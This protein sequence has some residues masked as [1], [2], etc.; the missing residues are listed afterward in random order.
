MTAVTMGL[1]LGTPAGLERLAPVGAVALFLLLIWDL[2]LVVPILLVS[3][4]FGPKFAFEFGNL[5]LSTGILLIAYLAWALRIPVREGGLSFKSGPILVALLAMMVAFV[6]SSL[7]SYDR[8]LSEIP[9]FMRFFQFLLYTGIF[10][11]VRQMEFSRAQIR[12]LII[13]MLMVGLAQGAYGAYQ[14]WSRP[15]YFV[16]GTF[17]EQHNLFASYV[18]FIAVIMVG[19][20]MEAR[21]LPVAIGFLAAA[22][23]LVYSIVFSFSRTG[24]ISLL[25]SFALFAFLPIGKVKRIVVPAVTGALAAGI[26]VAVPASV[27][28]RMRD[29][30]TT[31]AGSYVTLSF[32]YRQIMWREAYEDW[33]SSPVFGQGAWAYGMRDNF[34][35]KAGAE[36]GLVGL[37]TYLVLLYFILRSSWRIVKSPPADAFM[38]GYAVGFFP[39]AV[40]GLIVFNLAGDSMSIHR[41][42][43]VFWI[44]LA[45]MLQY[46]AHGSCGRGASGK[47]LS[48]T[49][50]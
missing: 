32:K 38:R 21:R 2:R 16:V 15:G 33:K 30:Y 29:I 10:V 47:N 49:T 24:Y 6:I 12:N 3:L 4:P 45:L 23:L 8:L 44:A 22:G 36:A 18:T 17:D 19:I 14:W 37:V 13:F 40:G 50:S 20:S 48:E 34:F 27:S 41:F 46:C 26:L 11:M 25:V 7:Q 28:E 42:M 31:A 9:V 5:Y 43:G 1:L 35:V 39:A